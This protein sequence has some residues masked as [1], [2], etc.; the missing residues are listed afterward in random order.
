[1]G[2]WTARDCSDL[3]EAVRR[4]E[5]GV[6]DA[7]ARI[8]GWL[9][10]APG[11]RRRPPRR[12]RWPGSTT[13]GAMRCGFPEVV[14]GPGKEPD[15]LA[16]I[17]LEILDRSDTLLVT[18]V[19]AVRAARLLDAIPD[20]VHHE[21]ARCVSVRRG[22][23]APGRPG[24]AVVA[25]GTADV[26]VAEEARVTAE[27]MGEAVDRALRRGGRRDPP[28]ARPPGDAPAGAGPRGGGGDGGGAPQ[29]GRGAGRRPGDR[30]PDQRGL[31]AGL[32]GLAPLLAMLNSCA[33]NVT[34]V[35]V[36]NGFGAGYV[37]SLVNRGAVAAPA[38][39][40]PGVGG[41]PPGR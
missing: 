17:A 23:R 36:D 2:G 7:L 33:P 34:V 29:R 32:G 39:A 18:R 12:S 26:P 19:D 41:G 20:A 6:D 40:E 10:G 15:D 25:A 37:A 3:L 28:P 21:R 9:P 8:G 14:F 4:G 24:V 5:T 22:A 31:R 13:T 11:A 38:P 30:R 16:S 1:M 35:N 27:T